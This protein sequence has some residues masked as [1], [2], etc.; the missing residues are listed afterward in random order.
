VFKHRPDR[1]DTFESSLAE[2]DREPA[3]AGDEIAVV[4]V[5]V[6]VVLHAY[7]MI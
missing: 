4:V 7:I 2:G 6:V 1:A 5:V 3:S